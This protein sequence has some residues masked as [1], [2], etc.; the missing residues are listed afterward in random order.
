MFPKYFST[1]M[2]STKSDLN[3]VKLPVIHVPKYKSTL[4]VSKYSGLLYDTIELKLTRSGNSI[5]FLLVS[6]FLNH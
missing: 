6:I 5:D 1:N 3:P 4:S 2:P